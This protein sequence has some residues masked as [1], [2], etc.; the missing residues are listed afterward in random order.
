M[1]TID[2]GKIPLLFALGLGM[3]ATH[4][5][6]LTIPRFLYSMPLVHMIMPSIEFAPICQI[7]YPLLKLTHHPHPAPQYAYVFSRTLYLAHFSLFLFIW[8]VDKVNP[9][10]SE[11][12]NL[13]SFHQYADDIRLYYW[14]KLFY[15]WTIFRLNFA[16]NGSATGS[17]TM[18][19]AWK[20]E[21]TSLKLL[22]FSNPRSKILKTL[23]ESSI[24]ISR[25]HERDLSHR[26]SNS[27]WPLRAENVLINMFP[28]SWIF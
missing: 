26:L 1:E 23:A 11:T 21:T 2:S 17:W 18:D 28:W 25:D 9:G 13:V 12:N 10:R 4:P 6:L 16:P 20:S 14:Y 3:S 15:A 7:A 5:I 22:H 8:L 19:F 27:I 24:P